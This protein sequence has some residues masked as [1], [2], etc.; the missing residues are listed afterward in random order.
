[1]SAAYHVCSFKPG[2]RRSEAWQAPRGHRMVH[3]E[4]G[5]HIHAVVVPKD[6][7]PPHFTAI[8]AVQH[9]VPSATP[10]AVTPICADLI[11]II[12]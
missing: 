8:Q 12:K 9:A 2:Q 10:F 11:D 3:V 1:M 5:G 6:I 7:D 4:A